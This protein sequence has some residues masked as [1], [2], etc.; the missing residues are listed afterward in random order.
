V[1]FRDCTVGSTPA[2]APRLFPISFFPFFS[3]RPCFSRSSLLAPRMSDQEQI[4]LEAYRFIKASVG[5][6]QDKAAFLILLRKFAAAPAAPVKAPVDASALDTLRT[7]TIAER[8]LEAVELSGNPALRYE[9]KWDSLDAAA[10]NFFEN[11]VLQRVAMALR[12]LVTDDLARAALKKVTRIVAENKSG[13]EPHVLLT[14]ETLTL[15]GGFASLGTSV[16]DSQIY[17]E[18]DA[19]LG[20]S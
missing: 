16:S 7:K 12:S 8:T 2:D 10:V 19:K 13:A 18:L 15:T 5:Y 4:A 11:N 6:D 3:P 20:I 14:G 9:V 17:R 1:S